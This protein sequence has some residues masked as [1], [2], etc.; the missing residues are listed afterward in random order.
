[1]TMRKTSRAWWRRRIAEI[2]Q[3]LSEA[4][5]VAAP[6][7]SNKVTVGSIVTVD[8]G[9]RERVFTIVGAA[10]AD[11]AEGKISNESPVGS[12]LLGH[13]KDDVVSTVGPT[14]R[15]VTMSILKIEH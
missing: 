1:M 2:N 12:A 15:E 6:K 14:G 4:T 8:M 10:E 5:V 11:V 7:K 3:I 9:G 13:K